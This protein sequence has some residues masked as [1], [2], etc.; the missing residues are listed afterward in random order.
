[1]RLLVPNARNA[2]AYATIR[3]LRDAA[4]RIVALAERRYPLEQYLAHAVFAPEVDRWVPTNWPM[5]DWEG[6]RHGASNTPAEAAYIDSVER[7]CAEERLDWIFPSVEGSSYVFAKNR[8]RLQARGVS[9]VCSE[10]DALRLVNDKLHSMAALVAAGLPAPRTFRPAPD[11]AEAAG[12]EVGFPAI[13]KPSYASASRGVFV[14]RNLTEFREAYATVARSYG[15][16]IVQEYIPGPLDGA[17]LRV[18]GVANA[19]ADVVGV[20]VTRT[21][22]TLFP[23][24]V[25]PP[26]VARS[27]SNLDVSAVTARVVKTL[28]IT[29]PFL[30]QYKVDARDGVPKI[31]EVNCKLSYRIWTAI[32]DGLDVPR[33]ALQVAQGRPTVPVEPVRS[34]TVFVNLPELWMAR[35][36][37]PT[38]ARR[39]SGTLREG[40]RQLD[41]YAAHF[42]RRPRIAM[43]WWLTFLGF[44]GKER[45]VRRL[46]RIARRGRGGSA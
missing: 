13:V 32:A 7:L 11:A 46:G 19:S 28:G 22:L 27:E 45:L 12:R 17:F 38:R 36:L 5:A 16:P 40:S 42:L 39:V 31:I 2:Q 24:A 1:V 44:V 23:D 18:I 9:L 20:H 8:R 25:L 26:A 21:L 15:T 43:L 33:L 35:C 10:L 14:A 4:E 29:G 6:G 41:P 3:S 37:D 34:G 30:V